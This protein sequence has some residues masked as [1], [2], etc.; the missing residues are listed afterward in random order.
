[1][2][3]K[4]N[5]PQFTSNY[6]VTH[7]AIYDEQ[8]HIVED[9][10][11]IY[12]KKMDGTSGKISKCTINSYRTN[13]RILVNGSEINIVLQHILPSIQDYINKSSDLLDVANTGMAET[14]KMIVKNRNQTSEI[15]VCTELI[16]TSDETSSTQKNSQVQSFRQDMQM[17]DDINICLCPICKEESQENTI[18]CDECNEW[19]H[20]SCLRLS[21]MKLPVTI[22]IQNPERKSETNLMSTQE[23]MNEDNRSSDLQINANNENNNN[24]ILITSKD[25]LTSQNICQEAIQNVQTSEESA[26]STNEQKRQVKQHSAN[27]TMIN[28]TEETIPKQIEVNN[29]RTEEMMISSTS[30]NHINKE[31][32]KPTQRKSFKNLNQKNEENKTVYITSLEQ[33]IKQQDQTIDRLKR[34]M[35]LLLNKGPPEYGRN[36]TVDP[37][38]C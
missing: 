12:K 17:Q 8:G 38:P 3:E 26:K 33:R 19:Y 35:E 13:S 37:D 11:K 32:T 25:D 27:Q 24:T 18:A 36:T 2:K 28:P 20:Y 29:I 16:K 4:F 6:N 15:T 10:Y 9:K 21:T 14:M 1:M 34:N 22:P 31:N 30:I 5:S 23:Q 7:E